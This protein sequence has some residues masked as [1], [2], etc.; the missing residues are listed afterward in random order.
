MVPTGSTDSCCEETTLNKI[1]VQVKVGSKYEA[2]S[3]Y[4]SLTEHCTLVDLHVSTSNVF[5]IFYSGFDGLA[6]VITR[7][8]RKKQ[9]RV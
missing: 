5:P 6:S 4:L 2:S 3:D 7:I 1:V 8:S 9:K